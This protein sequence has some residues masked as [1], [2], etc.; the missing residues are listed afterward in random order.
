[1]K[2]TWSS[3]ASKMPNITQGAPWE[4]IKRDTEGKVFFAKGSL[5]NNIGNGVDIYV[6]SGK[7]GS[8]HVVRDFYT[9]EGINE[10]ISLFDKNAKLIHYKVYKNGKMVEFARSTAKKIKSYQ[11]DAKTLV[12][13]LKKLIKKGK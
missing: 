13:G 12:N 5:V 7:N 9:S 10:V 11:L 2:T 1:M 4:V 8:T 3:I 6:R